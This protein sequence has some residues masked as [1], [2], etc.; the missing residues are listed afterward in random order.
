MRM[1]LR[2]WTLPNLLTFSR[3]V[4][5]PFL[6]MAIL[7]GR[8][9]PA[10]VIFLA[11]AVT[12]G[13]DG[14][15]ARRFG[16]ASPLGAYLDPIADKLFLVGTF[17]A[18]A[19]PGQ[20]G[21]LRVPFWLLLMVISRDLII[22]VVALILLL[23]LDVRQFPPSR[24][25]KVTTVV[26]IATLTAVLLGNLGAVPRVVAEVGFAVTAVLIFASGIQYVWRVSTKPP[27][28]GGKTAA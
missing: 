17:I 15:L 3:L 12:D 24:L 5:L 4:A 7:D 22:L 26:E 23:A 19:L 20:A 27:A 28:A 2:P 21:I 13:L 6:L 1:E 14:F 16:M 9:G 11:A 8:Y 10:S 18:C 25:G